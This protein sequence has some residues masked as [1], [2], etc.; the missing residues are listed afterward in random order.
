MD[1]NS[2]VEVDRESQPVTVNVTQELIDQHLGNFNEPKNCPIFWAIKEA[3]MP[4]ESVSY[5]EVKVAGE[6]H[7]L[8]QSATNWQWEIMENVQEVFDSM[9]LP[10]SDGYVSWVPFPVHLLTRTPKPFSFALDL[11][12]PTS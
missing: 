7:L 3:G 12:S 11:S 9:P 6:W 1:E 2:N 8:P 10:G 4:V 5:D